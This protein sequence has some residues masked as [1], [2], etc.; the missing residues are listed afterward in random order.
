LHYGG[1]TAAISVGAIGGA[2]W[3]G[4]R[5][6]R[7]RGRIIFGCYIAALL[8]LTVVG[9]FPTPIAAMLTFGGC[10]TVLGLAWINALQEQIPPGTLW[11]RHQH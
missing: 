5:Q 3:F 4:G 8:M 11:V 10:V 9:L 6:L 7:R 1:L 2:V